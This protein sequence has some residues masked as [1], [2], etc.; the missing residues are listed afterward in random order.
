MS[1]EV[2]KFTLADV[3]PIVMHIQDALPAALELMI[4]S[5]LHEMPQEALK[6]GKNACL[7]AAMLRFTEN[8]LRVDIAIGMEKFLVRLTDYLVHGKFTKKMPGLKISFAT[9]AALSPLAREIVGHFVQCFGDWM[10]ELID[11]LTA[12]MPRF[13]DD[14]ELLEAVHD[15]MLNY[16]G[17]EIMQGVKVFADGLQT[18]LL[19]VEKTQAEEPKK[20]KKNKAA[21]D[22][23]I[24]VGGGE[25]VRHAKKAKA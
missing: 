1:T 19:E 23:M 10:D 9:G 17:P 15:F 21:R 13:A 3:R 5:V 22:C 7:Q 11:D 25:C 18:A 20:G 24:C 4:E 16:F 12:E 2:K 6:G 14:D 8:H